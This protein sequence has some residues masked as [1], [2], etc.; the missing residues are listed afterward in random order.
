MIMDDSKRIFSSA[1]ASNII[2]NIIN[3]YL[4]R[5]TK[6]ICLHNKQKA[7]LIEKKGKGK[8]K[9]RKEKENSFFNFLQFLV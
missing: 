6:F 4:L 2:A 9:E 3:V 8:G 7:Y 1:F 5:S